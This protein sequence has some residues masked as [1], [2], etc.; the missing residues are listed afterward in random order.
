MLF[1]LVSPIF[2]LMFTLSE[3]IGWLFLVVVLLASLA[4]TAYTVYYYDLTPTAI[5]H[6]KYS[7]EDYAYAKPWF[8]ISPFLVGI[9]IARIMVKRR[10]HRC[11]QLL[12]YALYLS[13]LATFFFVA[14]G[15]YGEYHSLSEKYEQLQ[16]DPST[17]GEWGTRENVAYITL[18]HLGWGLALAVLTYF[19]GCGYC[20]NPIRWFLGHPIW[21]PL[22]KL[23]PI[24]LFVYFIILDNVL[25]SLEAFPEYSLPSIC[26]V[27]F[28]LTLWSYGVSLIV[29]LT[30]ESPV[31]RA[32]EWPLR[33]ILS[34]TTPSGESSGERVKSPPSGVIA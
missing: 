13:A 8:R 3:I 1:F 33:H 12:R 14:F 11:P 17:Q 31:G 21:F 26:A 34:K 32:L 6:T 4:A 22:A 19:V 30:L 27:A 5:R 10:T 28:S 23:T 24:V 25:H 2:L 16:D 29:H 9:G 18:S 15:P 7:Y 20:W